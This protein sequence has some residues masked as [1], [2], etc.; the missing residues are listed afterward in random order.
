M[1][2][3][4]KVFNGIRVTSNETLIAGMGANT[5][6]YLLSA[7]Q[8]GIE[9]IP[10]ILVGQFGVDSIQLNCCGAEGIQYLV[11]PKLTSDRHM[12]FRAPQSSIGS[13]HATSSNH[14]PYGAHR[15]ASNSGQLFIDCLAVRR[16]GMGGTG[17]SVGL[18]SSAEVAGDRT[19]YFTASGL[20]EFNQ[21]T[22]NNGAELGKIAKTVSTPSATLS[23]ANFEA[24]LQ[25]GL[26]GAAA[27]N[28]LTG[29]ITNSNFT[30]S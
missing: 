13:T 26:I 2:N 7:N 14:F 23:E 11:N 27:A 12:T 3:N 21:I 22:T 9:Q 8:D 5:E 1:N 28:T 15:G 18:G 24:R 16:G 25:C 29:C 20:I 10:G 6:Q 4:S 19:S 30:I 17:T